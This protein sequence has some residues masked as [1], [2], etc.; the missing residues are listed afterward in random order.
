MIKA[1]LP[2]IK[3]ANKLMASKK[4]KK[5]EAK[6]TIECT[7]DSLT[8]LSQANRETLGRRREQIKPGLNKQFRQLG[9]NVPPESTL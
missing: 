3:V 9:R 8:I 5:E 1:A 4:I 6:E 7:L 2:V